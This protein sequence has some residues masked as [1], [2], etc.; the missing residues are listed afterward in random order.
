MRP[1]HRPHGFPV[2]KTGHYC[3]LSNCIIINDLEPVVYE[4][5]VIPFVVDNGNNSTS[6]GDPKPTIAGTRS[7]AIQHSQLLQ[8]ASAPLVNKW[9]TINKTV[10]IQCKVFDLFYIELHAEDNASIPTR[11]CR[12]LARLAGSYVLT[13][14]MD[15]RHFPIV[16]KFASAPSIAF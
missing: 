10:S 5:D 11:S 6:K 13:T 15:Y 9:A 14:K 3:H 7:S 1:V 4:P 12:W 2:H 16:G 8:W